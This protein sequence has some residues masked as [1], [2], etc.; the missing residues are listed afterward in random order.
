M[1]NKVP[2]V[3]P[4][5]S[6]LVRDRLADILEIEPSSINEGD[7]FADDLEADSLALIELVEALEEELARALGRLPHRRRGSR[8]SQD[9]A[10]R[11]RLH[12]R[13]AWLTVPPRRPRSW[14]PV[15]TSPASTGRPC[16]PALRHRSWCADH[17]EL[18]S[19]ERLEFLGDAVLGLVVTDHLFAT[20]P[21]MPEGELAKVRASVVSAGALAAMARQLDIGGAL[22]LGRGEEASGGRDK[23][24]ILAD[25]TEAVLGALYLA[26][27]LDAARPVVLRFLRRPLADAVARPGDEDY[28]TRLQELVAAETD[29]PPR[30]A[31][32]SEGP[33]HDKVFH[34]AVEVPLVAAAPSGIRAEGE[35]KSKKQAEQAAAGGRVARATGP[36]GGR[37]RRVRAG[38]E[39]GGAC[40]SC[41]RSR[42]FD[43]RSTRRSSAS[44]S[45]R[46]RRRG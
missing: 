28:K 10:R 39:R 3:D 29:G 16:V 31:V 37:R 23:D 4:R 41:R 22:L 30:Y 13:P 5:S 38:R 33:D 44:A 24:S 12:P 27:G 8:G 9:G 42:P 32:T 25:A 1:S 2:W 18:P 11:R 14:P 34:A 43:A 40:L 45:R 46:S 26:G 6:T 36:R 19:N 21:E 17:P 7:A 20:Q 35:G 15:S